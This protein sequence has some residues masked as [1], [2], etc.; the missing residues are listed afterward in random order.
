MAYT[1]NEKSTGLDLLTDLTLSQSD[2]HIVGDVSDSGRA[3][4]ITQNLLE[5][6]IANSTN[7]VDELVANNYFTTELA[8]DTNFITQLQTAGIGSLEVEENGVS[9]ETG[10]NKINLI[11]N[12]PIATNPVTGEVEID[13]TSL[14]LG[15]GTK[16]AIDTNEVSNAT[17]TP[18]TAFT[19]SIPGGTLGTNDAIRFTI[20]GETDGGLGNGETTVTYGGQ[21][22][23]TV[24]KAGSHDFV[25]NGLIIADNATGAQKTQLQLII[26]GSPQDVI[27]GALTVDSTTNQNL[28]VSIVSTNTRQITLEAIVVEKISDGSG[29]QF[30]TNTV[31]LSSSD[32]LNLHTTPKELVPAPGAGKVIIVQGVVFSFT[33]G[34]T[35]YTD[36][37]AL[38]VSYGTSGASVF[39]NQVNTLL[40]ETL[41]NGSASFVTARS[42]QDGGMP[43]SQVN[44]SI[45]LAPDTPVAFNAGDGTLKVFITY[46]IITL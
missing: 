38:V 30:L 33:V 15:G 1:Q 16:L 34:G 23:G 32:I 39:G 9:V 29:G 42:P 17:T 11:T 25:I 7:F 13:L 2:L 24:V 45:I 40:S 14:G 31:S 44:D 46:Q 18:A 19:I 21:T 12:S 20:T 5:D 22:L 4:A 8:G 10:V 41:I 3:K 26:D 36:G 37:D 28:V 35:Q 43:L 27:N 6:Y